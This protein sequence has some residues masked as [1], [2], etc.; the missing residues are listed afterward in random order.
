MNIFPEGFVLAAV[1]IGIAYIVGYSLSE[2]S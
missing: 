1:V 2:L